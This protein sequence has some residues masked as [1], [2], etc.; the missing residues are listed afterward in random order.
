MLDSQGQV[1]FS[2]VYVSTF[3]RPNNTKVTELVNSV[4]SKNGLS[5][6][7]AIAFKKSAAVMFENHLDEVSDFESFLRKEVLEIAEQLEK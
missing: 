2:S 6:E 7:K 5:T 3:K 1:A 4:V